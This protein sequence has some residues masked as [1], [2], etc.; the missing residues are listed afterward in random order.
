MD[1]HCAALTD[2]YQLLASLHG[3]L[4]TALLAYFPTLLSIP[5]P[6]LKLAKLENNNANSK[7]VLCLSSLAVGSWDSSG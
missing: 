4:A 6:R 3:F 1:A 7:L 2:T 5:S